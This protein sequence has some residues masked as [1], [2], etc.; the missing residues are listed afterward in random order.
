MYTMLP[1]YIKRFISY[2]SM[3]DWEQGILELKYVIRI[4]Y[5]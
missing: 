1:Y 5:V 4:M 2:P 3:K